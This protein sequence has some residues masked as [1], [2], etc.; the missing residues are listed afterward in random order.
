MKF[1]I[2]DEIKFNV[3]GTS[4]SCLDYNK[5]SDFKHLIK[6]GNT[7]VLDNKGIIEAVNDKYASVSY[8]GQSSKEKVQLTFS[9]N[10]L[11]LVKAKELI[12]EI[13]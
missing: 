2:G 13:Y 11:I 7:N 6:H 9:L 10:D 4:I 8:I 5:A 12:Y 1:K 3:K